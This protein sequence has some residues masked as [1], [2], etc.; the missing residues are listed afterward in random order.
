M[1]LKNVKW[2]LGS[3]ETA[4]GRFKSLDDNVRHEAGFIEDRD[5][6]KGQGRLAE[7]CLRSLL[8]DIEAGGWKEENDAKKVDVFVWRLETRF[9][10]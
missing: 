1:S 8:Q 5:V 6:F 3:T 9:S 10:G 4:S 7:V 2:L